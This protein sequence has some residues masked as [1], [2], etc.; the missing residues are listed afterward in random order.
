MG[1]GGD[2]LVLVRVLVRLCFCVYL[3]LL[4]CVCVRAFVRACV[5]ACVRVCVCMFMYVHPCVSICTRVRL[6]GCLSV[7]VSWRRA[8]ANSLSLVQFLRFFLR[9]IPTMRQIL[10]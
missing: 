5:R 8:V 2:T 6:S 9:F 3:R 7:S 10:H 4:V 1:E